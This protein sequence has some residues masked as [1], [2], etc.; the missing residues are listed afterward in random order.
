MSENQETLHLL[1]NIQKGLEKYSVKEL[2]EAIQVALNKK[3]DRKREIDFVLKS[4]ADYYKVSVHTLKQSNTRGKIQ[5]AKQVCYCL[6]KNDLGL[7]IRYIAKSIF[8]NWPNSVAT[9][10][11]RYKNAQPNIKTDK[12]FLDIYNLFQQKLIKFITEQK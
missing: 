12:E 8:F 2:N 5:D 10:I 9:G 7:S 4:V 6:L 11:D 1:K 3:H